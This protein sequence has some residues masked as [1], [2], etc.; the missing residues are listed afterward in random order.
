MAYPG[1]TNHVPEHPTDTDR[2]EAL[3]AAPAGRHLLARV[4]GIEF[5][6]LLDA[7]E[8]PYPPNVGRFTSTSPQRRRPR[9]RTVFGR[10]IIFDPLHRMERSRRKVAEVHQRAV[11]KT[12]AQDVAE[13][14]NRIRT[15]LGRRRQVDPGSSAELLQALTRTVW[16]FGFWGN[17]RGYDRL[18]RS[19][20]N[21]LRP[22]AEALVASAATGWWWDDLPRDDQRYTARTTDGESGPPRGDQVV[23]QQVTAAEELRRE[24]RD[25]RMLHASPSAVPENASGTWWSIPR[26]A[27]WT[28]RAL[29]TVPALHLVCAEET[30]EERVTVWSLKISQAARV[31]EVR[32]PS[33]WGQL[34]EMAPINVTMSKLADWRRWTE[35]EGPFYLPDWSVIAEHYDGIHVTV[36]GYLT[37][38]SMPVRVADGYSVLAGWDPDASLW[39]RDMADASERIGEWEGDL[40]PI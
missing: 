29:P 22:V 2:V 13:A 8:L 38:R 15:D 9:E 18:L 4:A 31:F 21:E 1:P 24:E 11:A 20:L 6:D 14:V 33:D 26:P 10:R 36:G 32:E 30:S 25:A 7:L 23:A 37:T 28:S 17:E 39:L 35:R 12:R 34:V 5:V 27:L 3:L 16:G 19:A 40:T